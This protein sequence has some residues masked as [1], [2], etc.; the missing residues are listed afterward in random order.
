MLIDANIAI[1]MTEQGDPYENAIAERLNGI[2]KS[3]FHLNKIFRSPVEA[4]IAV[5]SSITNYNSLRPH[6]S[7]NYLTPQ[8][9]HQTAE[10]LIKKW[11]KKREENIQ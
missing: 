7:C 3:E 2:L 9:A 10:P 11:K 6:M 8:Q 1:S 4:Q 5:Q